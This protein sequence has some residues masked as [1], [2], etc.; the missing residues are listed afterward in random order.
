[1]KRQ[2]S[3]SFCLSAILSLSGGLQ[4]AY[5]FNIRGKVFANAQTGN[6]VLM[7]QSLMTGQ[8]RTAAK[9]LLPILAFAFGIVLAEQIEHKLKYENRIHWRQVIILIEMVL[10]GAVGFL[11]TEHNMIA[12]FLVSMSCAMQVQ[13]F[14]KVCGYG[15]A[16]TMCIGNLR[17]GTESLSQY[18]RSRNREELQKSLH[19]YGII[20][21]FAIGAGVGGLLSE[22]IGIYTIWASVC[23][24]LIDFIVMVKE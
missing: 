1:M 19:Y 12:N 4:D 8:F 24:L 18:I 16:S 5:T 23:L 6:V 3:E 15:Y 21:I 17:N 10:L 9:Y 2:T 11:P 13:A 7:S 22:T 20:F 14:R